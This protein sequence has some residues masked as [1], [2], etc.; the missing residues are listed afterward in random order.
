MP[1]WTSMK[2]YRPTSL[3]VT[4]REVLV[5]V[6]V[7]LISAP[8]TAAFWGSV[9]WPLIEPDE[10]WPGAGMAAVYSSAAKQN[11]H[12]LGARILRV[13]LQRF[14]FINPSPLRRRTEP[15]T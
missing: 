11:S 1:D 3:V 5:A 2:V 4:V 14:E 8:G 13:S 15:F 12:S 10:V 9:I 7:S 6:S